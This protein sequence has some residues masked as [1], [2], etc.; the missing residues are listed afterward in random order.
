MTYILIE[1]SSSFII[2]CRGS[3]ET[4]HI[5]KYRVEGMLDIKSMAAISRAEDTVPFQW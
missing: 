4:V 1:M 3:R 2:T 5:C